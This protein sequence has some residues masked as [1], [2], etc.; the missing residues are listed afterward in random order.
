M[1]KILSI[2]AILIISVAFSL[3]I[4][5]QSS[6]DMDGD[7]VKN[8]ED[9][10]LNDRGTKANKGCPSDNK[11]KDEE[12]INAEKAKK[13]SQK[14]DSLKSNITFE[15]TPTPKATPTPVTVKTGSLADCKFVLSDGCRNYFMTSTIDQIGV[16]LGLG[17]GFYNR[18]ISMLVYHGKGLELWVEPSS[19]RII[20]TKI[21]RYIENWKPSKDLKWGEGFSK[22]QKKIGNGQYSRFVSL[23]RLKYPNFTLYFDNT[24][25]KIVE[26]EQ[27]SDEFELAAKKKRETVDDQ[28]TLARDRADAAYAIA[29]RNQSRF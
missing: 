18:T 27:E 21:D 25:L 8:S 29:R 19:R 1:K 11:A 4:F 14:L 12:E 5:A 3:A 13:Q 6:D 22:L 9:V 15:P 2:L 26:Y 17:D 28:I 7:G 10:C 24:E 16:Q 23:E 20:V